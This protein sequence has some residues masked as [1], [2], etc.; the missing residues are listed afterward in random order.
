MKMLWWD[1]LCPHKSAL[2]SSVPSTMKVQ[3][4]SLSSSILNIS[5]FWAKAPLTT[6]FQDFFK[7]FHLRVTQITLYTQ[8]APNACFPSSCTLEQL[9]FIENYDFPQSPCSAV[10][11]DPPVSTGSCRSQVPVR[12]Q[13]KGQGHWWTVWSENWDNEWRTRS[14]SE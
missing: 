10:M 14:L 9:C 11:K 8:L 1:L 4:A 6:T 5:S 13:Y 2:S 3:M 12:S 7:I